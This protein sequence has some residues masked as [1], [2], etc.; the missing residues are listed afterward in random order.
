MATEK[1]T[2]KYV[3]SKTKPGPIHKL[4]AITTTMN[5]D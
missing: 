2:V 5:S 3:N 4:K 1:L